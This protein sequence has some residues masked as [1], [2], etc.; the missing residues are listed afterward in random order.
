MCIYI[1]IIW[2]FRDVL[3]EVG[4]VNAYI[5]REYDL[6]NEDKRK[7][8]YRIATFDVKDEPTK[9][10]VNVVRVCIC[11]LVAVQ[12]TTIFDIT[13]VVLYILNRMSLIKY[14]ITLL[15]MLLFN[16]LSAKI[17]RSRIG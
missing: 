10:Q 4:I 2:N 1:Y 3:D 16:L 11:I 9:L 5:D 12:Y 17:Q 6:C 8:F 14:S 7:Y 13:M 15:F